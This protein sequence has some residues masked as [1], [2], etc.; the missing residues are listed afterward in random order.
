MLVFCRI[1]NASPSATAIA[2]HR[3]QFEHIADAFYDTLIHLD[4]SCCYQFNNRD[5]AALGA[6]I[7]SF[8]ELQYLSM[9]RCSCGDLLLSHIG[10]MTTLEHLDIDMFVM[11]E[12]GLQREPTAIIDCRKGHGRCGRFVVWCGGAMFSTSSS[13]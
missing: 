8:T 9:E 3:S 1:S 5:S 10:N 13:P 2:L 12:V 11:S 6:A 4:M 7:E